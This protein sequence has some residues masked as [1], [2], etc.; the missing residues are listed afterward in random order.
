[1]WRLNLSSPR[2]KEKDDGEIMKKGKSIF[3]VKKKKINILFQVE[4]KQPK[5][6]LG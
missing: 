4:K 2:M 3:E 1:M 6:K 5:T